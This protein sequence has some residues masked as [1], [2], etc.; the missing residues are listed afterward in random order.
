MLLTL[1]DWRHPPKAIFFQNKVQDMTPKLLAVWQKSLLSCLVNILA[2]S[3]FNFYYRTLQRGIRSV[4]WKIPFPPN[5]WQFIEPKLKVEK[6][7]SDNIFLI[8]S[9]RV[10]W[11]GCPYLRKCVPIQDCLYGSSICT[12]GWRV[13]HEDGQRTLVLFQVVLPGRSWLSLVL[14][15]GSRVGCGCRALDQAEAGRLFSVDPVFFQ[16]FLHHVTGAVGHAQQQSLQNRTKKLRCHFWCGLSVWLLANTL[17]F[18]KKGYI[19]AGRIRCRRKGRKGRLW[20]SKQKRQRMLLF[21][22][23]QQ[24]GQTWPYSAQVLKKL[25]CLL[26]W[27]MNTCEI[28]LMNGNFSDLIFL[29][30]WYSFSWHYWGGLSF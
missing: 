20:L 13:V 30:W 24:A 4:P 6:S 19:H 1:R 5:K 29:T 26:K 8:G 12:S 27:H 2:G 25:I 3:G 7:K 23:G 11:R 21:G 22:E 14:A 10:N 18:G 17:A 28:S 16:H 9:M 15:V